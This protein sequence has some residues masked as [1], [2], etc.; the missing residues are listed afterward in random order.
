MDIENKKYR[1]NINK[2]KI[3]VIIDNFEGIISQFP[4]ERQNVILRDPKFDYLKG[5]KLLQK[6]TVNKDYI[7]TTYNFSKDK[8]NH[9]FK[10]K[11]RLFSQNPSLQSLPREF[12][13][14]I[15]DENIVDFDFENCHFVIL[16]QY[17]KTNNIY[18]ENIQYYVDNRDKVMKNLIKTYEN[19]SKLDRNDIKQGLLSILNGGNASKLND[20]FTNDLRN[21]I[22]AVHD[23]VKNAFSDDYYEA[24]KL[25]KK[26][27]LYSAS[28]SIINKILCELE[29]KALQV[30]CEFIETKGFV[31][32]VLMF[33]GVMA[34]NLKN[35]N[36]DDTFLKEC[37]DFVAEKTGIPLIVTSKPLNR[38][39]LTNFKT[40][41]EIKKEEKLIKDNDKADAKLLK[42]K[43]KVEALEEEKLDKQITKKETNK[44]LKQAKDNKEL[45]LLNAEIDKI[46]ANYELNKREKKQLKKWFCIILMKHLIIE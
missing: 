27:K 28:G 19:S 31:S 10:S 24:E 15:C 38:L 45:I 46:K 36:V 11:G 35:I 7:Y 17:C 5:L 22:K 9:N 3:E 44:T 29:R 33:D 25:V 2:Y 41:N 37:S 6:F 12:R 20:T 26:G 23:F 21:E 42:N 34:E 16:I 14:T 13:N 30:N 40:K 32:S 1:E 39:D 43:I 4:I 18:N 8:T